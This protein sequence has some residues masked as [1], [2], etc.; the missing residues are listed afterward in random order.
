MMFFSRSGQIF[1]ALLVI[2]AIV[3]NIQAKSEAL[4]EFGHYSDVKEKKN[5]FFNYL[6]PLVLEGNQSIIEQRE[7]LQELVDNA[8]NLSFFQQRT[9]TRL[10]ERY[11]IKDDDLDNS[12]IIETLLIRVAPVPPSLVLAQAA[13]ESAWGTSRFAREGNNLFGQWCYKKGCGMVPLQRSAGTKHE[14]ARF[15]SAAEA[16]A[17]YMRNLNTHSAYK[18]LRLRRAELTESKT[19]NPNGHQLAETLLYYSE[20]REVYVEEVQA[21]IRINQLHQY[22]K[23]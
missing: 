6:L 9:L 20:L 21:V 14:V 13:I 3:V 22:D 11:R 23:L 8:D 18:T 17:A 7:Q 15:D 5:A 2:L 12:E 16:V 19:E 1:A 4:P 10:A